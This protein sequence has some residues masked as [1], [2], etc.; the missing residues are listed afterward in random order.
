MVHLGGKN[1]GT[2]NGSNPG[3]TGRGGGFPVR[4]PTA[5]SICQMGHDLDNQ[6]IG[7]SH[8]VAGTSASQVLDQ[9]FQHV[10]V[11]LHCLSY[12]SKATILI[13][14]FFQGESTI[15]LEAIIR[16]SLTRG[17]QH[18]QLPRKSKP[19]QY[20]GIPKQKTLLHLSLIHI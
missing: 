5:I 1:K 13:R 7:T 6:E 4:V 8:Y 16:P 2:K 19:Q 11:Q 18:W 10:D 17:R 3:S 14:S 15:V 9:L 20:I 12:T